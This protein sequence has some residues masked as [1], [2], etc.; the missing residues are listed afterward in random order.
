[1]C[2][3]AHW[4]AA[5]KPRTTALAHNSPR[6]TTTAP[7]ASPMLQTKKQKLPGDLSWG[8]VEQI[9]DFAGK[10]MG[11][12]RDQD[13]DMLECDMLQR[14]KCYLPIL[15]PKPELGAVGDL[16]Q[17]MHVTRGLPFVY[18]DPECYL[19]KASGKAGEMATFE[20]EAADTRGVLA[21]EG[22]RLPLIYEELGFRNAANDVHGDEP[23][24]EKP[25]FSMTKFTAE[26]WRDDIVHLLYVKYYKKPGEAV[27]RCRE[28]M[29]GHYGPDHSLAKEKRTYEEAI[30]LMADTIVKIVG[31]L[32]ATRHYAC[33]RCTVL[34]M[35]WGL[36]ERRYDSIKNLPACDER[37]GKLLDD[38]Y[39][40]DKDY[41]AYCSSKGHKPTAVTPLC[42]CHATNDAF[43]CFDKPDMWKKSKR[44]VRMRVDFQLFLAGVSIESDDD[45]DSDDPAYEFDEAAAEVGASDDDIVVSDDDEPPPASAADPARVKPL[46]TDGLYVTE[47]T[48][49]FPVHLIDDAFELRTE[50]KDHFEEVTFDA[51]KL[52]NVMDGVKVTTV[53]VA[54]EPEEWASTSSLDALASAFPQYIGNAGNEVAMYA[55]FEPEG[56]EF[57]FQDT[58]GFKGKY[59]QLAVVSHP[60][61]LCVAIDPRQVTVRQM[62]D[63]GARLLM[64]AGASLGPL[65]GLDFRETDGTVLN[66]TFVSKPNDD[67]DAGARVYALVARAGGGGTR[68][69]ELFSYTPER[70]EVVLDREWLVETASREFDRR[71]LSLD[72]TPPS[73]KPGEVL[74]GFAVGMFTN[75][76]PPPR[77]NEGLPTL[78]L[79]DGLGSL[80]P[81]TLTGAV[82][83][84]LL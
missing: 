38:G 39:M 78:E 83:W 51:V 19:C 70:E 29:S 18:S 76:L 31:P 69:E 66:R 23:G 63:K 4:R 45:V 7:P 40:V 5:T 26:Q 8:D 48:D 35:H 65:L 62:R 72:F 49:T 75:E 57:A 17:L 58:F 11:G 43:I 68:A 74:G 13:G 42:P 25:R 22:K 36:D 60:P 21:P 37:H 12:G 71:T 81:A 77:P 54:A 79:R 24:D 61:V 46:S 20:C 44:E 33:Q 52:I 10:L 64:I 9:A 32:N 14:A 84:S 15:T 47:T 2:Q 6:A 16:N 73:L 53:S 1:M 56:A 50:S 34:G 59:I 27:E 80:S 55:V 30:G 67:D 3:H 82:C 28:F 41:Q